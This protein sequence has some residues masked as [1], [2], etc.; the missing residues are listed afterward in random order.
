L[1]RREDE[2]IRY[3]VRKRRGERNVGGRER[4]RRK[5]KIIERSKE[6]KLKER[7]SSTSSSSSKGTSCL[8]DRTRRSRYL[9]IC[10]SK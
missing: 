5:R 10:K 9:W 4:E 7:S 8:V 6:E 1:E 3:V 2:R